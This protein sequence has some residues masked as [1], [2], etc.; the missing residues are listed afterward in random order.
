MED[1]IVIIRSEKSD[2]EKNLVESEQGTVVASKSSF[3]KKNLVYGLIGLL[4]L[5]GTIA[6]IFL[7]VNCEHKVDALKI[8][9]PSQ[10]I[11]VISEETKQE[12]LKAPKQGPKNEQYVPTTFD[13]RMQAS[14]LNC[15]YDRPD[16]MLCVGGNWSNVV[17]QTISNTI[18]AQSVTASEKALSSQYLLNCSN[19]SDKCNIL[20]SRQDFESQ[21]A[22]VANTGIPSA[23]CLAYNGLQYQINPNSC[24]AKCTDGSDIVLKQYQLVSLWDSNDD[25][26]ATI[27]NV[28][29]HLYN[30]G[31]VVALVRHSATVARYAGSTPNGIFVNDPTDQTNFGYRTFKIVGWNQAPGDTPLQYWIM[32]NTFSSNWGMNGYI[33]TTLNEPIIEGYYGYVPQ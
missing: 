10:N 8:S 17:A 31:P 25:M 21:L 24:D 30:F 20:S 23:S 9:V 1:N 32:A 16:E 6:G 33:R 19:L 2:L 11:E 28:K 14:S 18:C 26:N 29:N 12:V 22:F 15:N 4:I 27:L 5:S 13:L 7:I 3:N